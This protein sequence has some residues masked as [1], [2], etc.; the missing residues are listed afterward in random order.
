MVPIQHALPPPCASRGTTCPAGPRLNAA[1][2]LELL[3]L[4]PQE[5]EDAVAAAQVG[6]LG[7]QMVAGIWR[8]RLDG[9]LT[10]GD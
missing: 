1:C 7:R 5:F 3:T 10:G 4:L 6:R 9:V 8:K 2:M